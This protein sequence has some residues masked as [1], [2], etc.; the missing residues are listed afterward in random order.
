MQ[1]ALLGGVSIALPSA[2]DMQRSNNSSSDQ[3]MAGTVDAP[4]S[5][6]A[7]AGDEACSTAPFAA[8]KAVQPHTTHLSGRGN[9]PPATAPVDGLLVGGVAAAVNAPEE[10]QP[11]VPVA[12]PSS[13]KPGPQ[14]AEAYDP[15]ALPPPEL[16]LL[17]LQQFLRHQQQE[18]GPLKRM[19]GAGH[20]DAGPPA[21]MIPSGAALPPPLLPHPMQLPAGALRVAPLSGTAAGMER[22]Q[23]S[24]GGGG[25]QGGPS[26]SASQLT[27]PPGH[28]PE[29]AAGEIWNWVGPEIHRLVRALPRKA[30]PSPPC[31]ATRWAKAQ[32][33]ARL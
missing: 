13:T 22:G 18:G 1:P 11:P 20:D 24:S 19:R 15:Q 26:T 12:G 21:L 14:P 27:A 8:P 28:A 3:P 7:P 9:T 10:Q 30:G 33:F 32:G 5:A 2:W 6:S 4:A 29:L 23:S 17:H 16:H 25:P 31:P